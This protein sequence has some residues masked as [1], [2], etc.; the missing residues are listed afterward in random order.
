ME[1]CFDILVL[2]AVWFDL[3]L[4]TDQ[5]ALGTQVTVVQGPNGMS[6]AQTI[7]LLGP[8]V[9]MSLAQTRRGQR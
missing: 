3:S 9:L 4:Q 6:L 7:V 5:T 8:L 2:I 1:I